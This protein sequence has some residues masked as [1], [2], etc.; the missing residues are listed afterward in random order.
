LAPEAGAGYE[1]V[2]WTCGG[3]DWTGISP[4]QIAGPIISAVR[5]S[6]EP[7]VSLLH[8]WPDATPEALKILL[9][10]LVGTAEF[11]RL[12]QLAPG[13]IPR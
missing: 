6:T 1:H 5:T 11:L 3:D 13:E 4:F 9:D 7:S 2:H 8:S 10:D 12:D